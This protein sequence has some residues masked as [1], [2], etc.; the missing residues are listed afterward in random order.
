[1]FCNSTAVAVAQVSHLLK[2]FELFKVIE[3]LCYVNYTLIKL[4][5]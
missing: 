1:M 3:I 5:K 2:I 4:L